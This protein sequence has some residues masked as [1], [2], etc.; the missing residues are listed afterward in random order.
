MG[1]DWTP[2]GNYLVYAIDTGNGYGI[3]QIPASGGDPQKLYH[4]KDQMFVGLDVHPDGKQI[5]LSTGV[6]ADEVWV[7][8]NFLPIIKR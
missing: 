6:Q 4:S 2:D 7:M 8:E 3:S 1:I 5:A